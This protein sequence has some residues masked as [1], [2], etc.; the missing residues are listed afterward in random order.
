MKLTHLLSSTIGSTIWILSSVQLTFANTTPLPP[1]PGIRFIP[2]QSEETNPF[3]PD[4]N[5]NLNQPNNQYPPSEPLKFG[6]PVSLLDT[7]IRQ[8]MNRYKSLSPGMFFVD[9]QTG[10]YLDING[11]RIFSA[12]STIKFPILVALFEEIEAGRI[13]LDELLVERADL[14]VGGS[15]DLQYKPAGSKFTVLETATK[16]MTISD[17]VATN[18]IIDRLG[19]KNV[20]NKRFRHWGLQQT[21][22]N[23][24]LVDEYGTNKTSAKDLVKL[25][26]LV[27]NNQL[28]NENSRTHIYNMMGNCHNQSLLPKGLGTGAKIYHKTGTLRFVLGDAGIVKTASGKVYLAGII[29]QR[30]NHDESAIRFIREVSRLV[31]NYFESPQNLTLKSI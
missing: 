3:N 31:Y 1:L 15:G 26:A 20:L 6:K 4:V 19:G 7:Q 23:H 28:I 8:L 12:A 5:S 14:K 30:P 16:M 21:Q 25:A 10:D 22:I 9:L 18:M 27:V 11:D 13:R 24:L 17:N 2:P 29:V